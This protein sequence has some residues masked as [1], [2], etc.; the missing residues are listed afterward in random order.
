LGYVKASEQWQFSFKVGLY[1][2]VLLLVQALWISRLPY[3]ALRADLLLPLM[4]GIALEWP[5]F[6]CF[7]WAFS[8]GFVV[9]TLS[10]KFWGLHVGSYVAAICLVNIASERLELRN[11]VYQMIFVGFCA[12]GQSIVLSVFLMLEPYGSLFLGTAW[13]RII[14]RTL[15]MTILT[16]LILY[17]VWNARKA[18]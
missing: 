14:M 16:P 18:K 2:F 7:L 12:F 17:P 9:D 3:P 15:F 10:G 4:F 5:P 11:P 13:N 8:W 1:S 6:P